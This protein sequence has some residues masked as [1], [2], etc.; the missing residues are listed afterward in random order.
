MQRASLIW[1][2]PGAL[3]NHTD[4]LHRSH[5]PRSDCCGEVGNRL[6]LLSTLLVC[7]PTNPHVSAAPCTKAWWKGSSAVSS[8]LPEITFPRGLHPIIR[9]RMLVL[10]WVLEALLPS[11]KARRRLGQKKF[12]PYHAWDLQ[13]QSCA[14]QQNS[15][16]KRCRQLCLATSPQTAANIATASTA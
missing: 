5:T 4:S 1:L 6:A 8:T 12:K 15:Q 16:S 13:L 9:G 14:L 2:E 10:P 3:E 7:A 11:T